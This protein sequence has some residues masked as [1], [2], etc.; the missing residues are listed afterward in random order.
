[1]LPDHKGTD[2]ALRLPY[3]GDEDSAAIAKAG[4][5]PYQELGNQRQVQRLCME[6]Q[7]ND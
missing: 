2:L 5:A 4:A 7:A 3:A 6:E 1:V